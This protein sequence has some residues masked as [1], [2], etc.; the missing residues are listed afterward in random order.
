M[1]LRT[2]F[3]PFAN[4][5]LQKLLDV[6]DLVGSAKPDER[7]VMTYVAQYFHAFSTFGE[8]LFFGLGLLGHR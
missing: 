1:A 7:S 5:I 6:E 3:S 2:R 8:R 4:S